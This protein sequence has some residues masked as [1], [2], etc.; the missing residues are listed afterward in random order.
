[1]FKRVLVTGGLGF[2][3]SDFVRYLSS[4]ES[5]EKLTVL[6]KETYAADRSRISDIDCAIVIG[7]I[8]DAE[9]VERVTREHDLVVN[10]AAESHNDNSI[11]S[12][13]GFLASNTLG[14]FRL[15]EAARRNDFHFHQVSTDEVFG[16]LAVDT[17]EVF[18]EQSPLRP[19]SPYSASKASAEQLVGAWVRTY[20]V[21][22]TISNS[23]NNFGEF[24]H[25]EKFIP[26]MFELLASG[27]SLELYGDGTNVRDW[28]YVR[29]HS[30]GVWKIVSSG[31]S[32]GERFNLSARQT[33]SNLEIANMINTFSGRPAD[34][35][36]FIVDRPG[37]D[38]RYESSSVL[39][40]SELGWQAKGPDLPSWLASEVERVISKLAAPTRSI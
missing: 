9:L 4:L 24:Q 38:R 29:D 17:N 12:P 30:V 8:C 14:V 11:D 15:L 36:K 27:S 33:F 34:R 20:R 2:M 13:E 16:D 19:S 35:I 10:F 25:R 31:R 23:A 21:K 3:G 22:A 40:E 1:M 5:I 6:D 37:H 7:D 18:D 39:A 28:L 26:R 32:H